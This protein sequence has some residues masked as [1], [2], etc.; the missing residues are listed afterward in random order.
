MKKDLF[1]LILLLLSVVSSAQ[2]DPQFSQYMFNVASF[3]PGSAGSSDMI[4][5]SGVNRQQWVGFPGAPSASHFN[6][7]TP[8]R[9]FGLN[10]GV[11][12]SILSDNLGFN[13]DLGIS[14]AY[15]YRLDIGSGTLGIGVNLGLFNKALEA[16]WYIPSDLEGSTTPDSDP[17]IPRKDESQIAFDMGFGLFYTTEDLYFGISTSHLNQAK[18]KYE[19]STPYLARHYY[20]VAGYRFQMSNPLFEILPSALI[21]T[22]GRA[23][24]IDVSTLVRYNKKFWGGVSYRAGDAVTGIIGFELFNGVRVGYSYDFNTSAIGNYSKGSHEFTLGYCFSLSLDKTP[25][26]YRSIRFL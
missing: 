18:I 10:S 12:F 22:D 16:D 26:K 4:C 15:A 8:I 2:Q 11:G 13:K 19:T 17:L 21:K 23:N 1:V 6:I 5:L 20:A 7:N 9:P 14:A 24:S 25:L 3:N